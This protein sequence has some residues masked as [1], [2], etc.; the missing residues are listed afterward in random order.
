[1]THQDFTH[2]CFGVGAD[3][4]VTS[5]Q[6]KVFFLDLKVEGNLSWNEGWSVPG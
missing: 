5:R 6:I 4:I 3:L 2:L 1:M